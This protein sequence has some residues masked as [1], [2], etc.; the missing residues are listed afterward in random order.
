MVKVSGKP[1]SKLRKTEGA[2]T[3]PKGT[4][5][6]SRKDQKKA[7]TR[8]SKL[9]ANKSAKKSPKAGPSGGGVGFPC[10]Q[11]SDCPICGFVMSR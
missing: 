11:P 2:T 9:A 7:L 10:D 8:K 3:G 5:K 6:L 4:L 1:K